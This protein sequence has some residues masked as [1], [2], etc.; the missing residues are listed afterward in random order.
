[1]T[2]LSPTRTSRKPT[3]ERWLE[4][5][6]FHSRWLMAPFY[7]GLVGAL[8]VLLGVFVNE[9]IHEFSHALTMSPEG[10]ILMVLSLIDCRWRATCC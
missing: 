5:G 7:L 6:L 3:F 10:A 2:D 4:A 1:M 8:V 9:M